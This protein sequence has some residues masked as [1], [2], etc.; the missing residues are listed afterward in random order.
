MERIGFIG[1]GDM[2]MGMAKNILKK[3]FDLTAYDTRT[4]RLKELAV[5]GATIAQSP[6]EV[7]EKSSVVFIMVFDGP[8]VKEVVSG[9]KGLLEGMKPGSTIICTSTI[10]PS[11]MK[12]VGVDVSQKGVNLID[13]PVSGGATRAAEG[14]LCMMA[15]AKKE[16]FENCKDIL[17]VVGKDIYHVGEEIGMGQVVKASHQVVVGITAAGLAEALVLG[18]KAGVNPEILR[19]VIGSGVC[20]SFLF[21][22]WSACI[23]DRNFKAGSHIRTLFKDLGITLKTGEDYGVPLFATSVAYEMYK[24]AMKM[25]PDDD[26]WAIVKPLEKLVGVEVKKPSS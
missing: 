21:N 25:A 14:T 4:E 13:S 1:A 5:Q 2:G 17:Q 22:S 19:K 15:A 26:T 20:G 10:L 24:A 3:G 7:G 6:R 8:Q 18:T 11:E 9:E 12:E 16:L 23:L